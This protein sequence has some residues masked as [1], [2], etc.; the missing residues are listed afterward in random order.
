MTEPS[1]ETKSVIN[2]LEEFNFKTLERKELKDTTTVEEM[3]KPS[4]ETNSVMNSLDKFSFKTFERKQ[5]TPKTGAVHVHDEH[6]SDDIENDQTVPK[7][8][9]RKVQKTTP[10]TAAAHIPYTI[11]RTVIKLDNPRIIKIRRTTPPITGA[12]YMPHTIER[13]VIELVNKRIIKVLRKPTEN[14]SM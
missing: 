1:T 5:T 9:E 7:H 8:K 14:A 13:N 11:E 12:G 6:I 10:K 3:S 4:T 2:S